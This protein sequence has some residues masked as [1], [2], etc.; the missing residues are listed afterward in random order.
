MRE[1]WGILA[2]WAPG[3]FPAGPFQIA[4]E[5]KRLLAFCTQNSFL[6]FA[7]LLLMTCIVLDNFSLPY[8][9]AN[10]DF[11]FSFIVLE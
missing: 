7:S 2:R 3:E 8:D 10:V 9:M 11:P 5:S 4:G 6:C 1:S